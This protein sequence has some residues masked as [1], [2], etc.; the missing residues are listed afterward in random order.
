MVSAAWSA[1]LEKAAGAHSGFGALMAPNFPWSCAFYKETGAMMPGE[2]ASRCASQLR[3][4][5]ARRCRLASGS[6]GPRVAAWP[7]PA[8][9]QEFCPST[10]NVRRAPP[11]RRRQRPAEGNRCSTSLHPRKHRGRERSGAG[12]RV[13]QGSTD[14]VAVET[15]I[16][17]RKGVERILRSLRASSRRANEAETSASV[18]KIERP[19][20]LRWCFGT[21]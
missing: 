11:A 4:N 16:F 21:I 6:T 20:I 5:P 8:D 9:P 13:H 14:E 1:L 17:A 18:T 15:S 10:P 3:R 2:T 12:G 19:K 7:A